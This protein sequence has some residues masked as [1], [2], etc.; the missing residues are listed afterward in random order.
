MP[1]ALLS[2]LTCLVIYFHY[3]HFNS[4][5]NVELQHWH[6]HCIQCS[7]S[8]A[9]QKC[10]TPDVVHPVIFIRCILQSIPYRTSGVVRCIQCGSFNGVRSVRCFDQCGRFSAVRSVRC[11]D[12]CGAF[13]AVHSA[14]CVQRG[15][16]SAVRSARC[17]Q[18]VT[19]SEECLY[20]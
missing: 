20:G 12:Q 15:A 13:G 2:V 1:L 5:C 17:V 11:V 18:S 6:C 4:Y 9:E 8:D 10:K 16:F 3:K 19:P 7:A 14:E